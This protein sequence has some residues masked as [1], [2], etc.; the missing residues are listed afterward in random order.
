MKKHINLILMGLYVIT[1]ITGL[2][3]SASIL[4][5]VSTALAIFTFLV[6]QNQDKHKPLDEREK[7]IV[8]RASSVSFQ[9][10]LGLLIVFSV[11]TDFFDVL[12]YI[13]LPNFLSVIMGFGFMTFVS[14]YDYYTKKI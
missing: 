12:Q 13:T 1:L 11:A 4:T 10:L 2:I 6:V 9:I 8:E 7:L 3:F 14:M 5:N